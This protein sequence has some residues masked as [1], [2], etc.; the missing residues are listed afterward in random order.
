LLELHFQSGVFSAAFF[1]P[2]DQVKFS[3]SASGLLF[4]VLFS[5]FCDTLNVERIGAVFLK[6][7]DSPN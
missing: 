5:M 2:F 4:M 3:L 1:V 6:G 7:E